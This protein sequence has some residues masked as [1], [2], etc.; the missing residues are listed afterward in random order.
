VSFSHK[1]L[2]KTDR[3]HKQASVLNTVK[4]YL[5]MLTTGIFQTTVYRT[6]YAVR[7]TITATAE[8]LV[9]FS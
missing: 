7:S 2:K 3:H 6:S 9:S 8:L 5:L 1:K 4:K